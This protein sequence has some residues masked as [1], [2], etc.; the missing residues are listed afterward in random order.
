M[1]VHNWTLLQ[2][3]GLSEPN[4]KM[5]KMD[6]IVSD[7]N[8][9]DL[10]S[11]ILLKIFWFLP[12]FDIHNGVA[13]TCKRF[14]EFTRLPEFYQLIT[15]K[16]NDDV[17]ISN[18]QK[19]DYK[20]EF[21]NK[22][23]NILRHSHPDCRLNIQVTKDQIPIGDLGTFAS[24]IQKLSMESKFASG[25]DWYFVPLFKN[26]EELKLTNFEI[27]GEYENYYLKSRDIW[28]KFPK[29]NSLKIHAGHINDDARDVINKICHKYP[30]LKSLM[31]ESFQDF[32]FNGA[33]GSGWWYTLPQVEKFH[34]LTTI[35]VSIKIKPEVIYHPAFNGVKWELEDI[36]TEFI[37]Y[38]KQ[39]CPKITNFHSKNNYS[40]NF[41]QLIILEFHGKAD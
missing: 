6:C 19:L 9:L 23:H 14:L 20:N 32:F 34:E 2:M 30:S 39:K 31:F 26:V 10:P 36:T 11:E 5:Q 21:L 18:Q 3:A 27:S 35:C 13:M 16:T 1:G 12:I 41:T 17:P 8:I 4:A 15:L 37:S 22:I 24:S 33:R 7:L 25:R 29:L 40:G 28:T 38:L